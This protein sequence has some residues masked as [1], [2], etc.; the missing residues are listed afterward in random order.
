MSLQKLPET[1]KGYS[2]KELLRIQEALSTLPLTD[3]LRKIAKNASTDMVNAAQD[4][5]WEYRLTGAAKLYLN[6]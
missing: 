4:M 5:V 1:Y 6:K 2:T 3:E